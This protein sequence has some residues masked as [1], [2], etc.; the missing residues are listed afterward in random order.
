[1]FSVISLNINGFVGWL[2]TFLLIVCRIIQGIA[3]GGEMVGAFIYTVEGVESYCKSIHHSHTHSNTHSSTPFPAAH[4][5]EGTGAITHG[6]TAGSTISTGVRVGRRTKD[7]SSVAS[8]SDG[9]N[10]TM[11]GK[12]FWGACCK[13]TGNVGLTMGAYYP[14][15]LL[16]VDS[17]TVTELT[18]FGI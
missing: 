5:E 13:A 17:C 15:C 9:K 12:G 18:L 16:F 1:M 8:R 14:I 4:I 3:A 11:G 2:A 10:E 7:R 6:V